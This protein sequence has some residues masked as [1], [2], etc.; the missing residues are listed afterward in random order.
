[1]D[2][3]LGDSDHPSETY[4]NSLRFPNGWST[5][6]GSAEKISRNK[7]NDY[8]MSYQLSKSIGYDLNHSPKRFNLQHHQQQQSSTLSKNAK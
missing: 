6:G 3:N 5:G 7:H 4:K 1:M 8:H 2:D